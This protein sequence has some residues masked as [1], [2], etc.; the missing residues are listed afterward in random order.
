MDG[1]SSAH[2]GFDH[3]E[4]DLGTY[5]SFS[6]GSTVHSKF[7][8][9]LANWETTSMTPLFLQRASLSEQMMCG[10]IC[11]EMLNAHNR[12]IILP[13]T[14]IDFCHCLRQARNLIDTRVAE[15]SPLVLMKL[16][17]STTESRRGEM[18]EN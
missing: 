3:G 5:S 1:V 11:G 8:T 12:C 4:D 17:A 6:P 16:P 9:S 13:L 10:R 2:P 15:P 7:K 18:N 14:L